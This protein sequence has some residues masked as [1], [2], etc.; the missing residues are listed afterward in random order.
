ML[1]V[2]VY[3]NAFFK[4]FF[5]FLQHRSGKKERKLKNELHVTCLRF[6]RF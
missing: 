4:T 1:H 5:F 6:M 2:H 3:L